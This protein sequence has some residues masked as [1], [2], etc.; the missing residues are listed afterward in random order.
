MDNKSRLAQQLT[1]ITTTAQAIHDPF[2]QSFFLLV[3]IAYLQAFID[4][5]KRTSRLAC[6]I[7]LV[8]NNLVPLSFNDIDKD[9]YASAVLVTYERNNVTPLAELYVSSYLRSCKLYGVTV[10][11]MGIDPLRVQYR[12]ARRELIRAIVQQSLHGDALAKHIQTYTETHV[13][14]EHREKFAADLQADLANLA[15]FSIAGMGFSVRELEAWQQG[16]SV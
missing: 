11:A 1:A 4:V 13:P 6:N 16:C 7:P 9:D 5:N 2:E 12:Q 8:R 14:P 3:H 15:P 10:E